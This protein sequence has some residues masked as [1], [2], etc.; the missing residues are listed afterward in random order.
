ML[1]LQNGKAYIHSF[2]SLWHTWHHPAA[3]FIHAYLHIYVYV[4]THTHTQAHT[5]TC[6]HANPI[7]CSDLPIVSLWH[8]LHYQAAKFI[9]T[10]I[11]AHTHTH[12]HTRTYTN[13]YTH[14]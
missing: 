1:I 8:T 3:K 14:M 13:T 9:H 4:Y 12:I 5:Q 2:T 6:K 11:L 10:Y 7:Q